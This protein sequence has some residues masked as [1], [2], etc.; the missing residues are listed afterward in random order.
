LDE[1]IQNLQQLALAK[2]AEYSSSSATGGGGGVGGGSAGVSD[3]SAATSNDKRFK[4]ML[5][6]GSSNSAPVSV[7]PDINNMM[8][9]SLAEHSRGVGQPYAD[10]N[11]AKSMEFLLDEDNKTAVQVSLFFFS[12]TLL[13][14]CTHSTYIYDGTKT[15]HRRRSTSS[16]RWQ[17]HFFCELS[18]F[19]S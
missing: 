8:S 17:R 4:S 3:A 15:I 18:S 14:L 19:S 5:N 16:S 6:L 2:R 12:T 1:L 9:L 10:P 13:D 7:E 11:R